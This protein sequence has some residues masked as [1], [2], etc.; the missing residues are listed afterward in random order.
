[1]ARQH[2]SRM[3]EMMALAMA[4]LDRED[5]LIGDVNVNYNTDEVSA[6]AVDSKDEDK[7]T[8]NEVHYLYVDQEL[9]QN[10]N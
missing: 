9:S 10:Q 7:K 1:M 8:I 2:W 4:G 6:E 5:T 3:K